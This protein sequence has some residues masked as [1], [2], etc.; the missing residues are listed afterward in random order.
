MAESVD[1]E[2]EGLLDGLEGEDRAD[3]VALLDRLHDD[4][5]SLEELREAVHDETLVFLP[6][7]R[8]IGGEARYTA[9]EVAETTGVDVDLLLRMR[10]AHG[11]PLATPDTR[12]FTDTDVEATR[13]ARGFLDAGVSAEQMLA[14]VRVLGRG[15]AQ[16]AEVMREIVLEMALEPGA[17]ESALARRYAE[18]AG[19]LVPMTTPILDQ[20]LRLHLRNLVRTEMVSAAERETGRLPGAREVTVGFADLVGF[21]RL[22]E[23]VA[24]EELGRVADRLGALA[25]DV[26][27]PPVRLVKLIGDAAMLVGDEPEPVLEA[28]LALVE[29]ADAEGE[30][31]PQLRAGIAAGE[32]LS[33]AGDWFG[34]PV[35]LASRV[36]AIAYP[37]SVLATR[38][39]RDATRDTFRWSS[40]RPRAIKGLEERVPLY[41]VRRLDP[42]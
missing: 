20:M 30:D 31:F 19:A 12:I 40:T 35:N 13:L 11:L 21:T 2:A 5:T 29:A 9:A 6:A 24:P 25:A 15:L 17:S 27:A 26:V 10:R 34:R 38:E 33:R 7:E 18:L 39:V 42:A 14:V 22:G 37:G 23:K 32:A 28:S 1:W 36:T 16:A 4:G 41:R 3:R 8:M